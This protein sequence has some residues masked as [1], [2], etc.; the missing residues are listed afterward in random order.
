[1]LP[2]NNIVDF[3]KLIEKSYKHVIRLDVSKL[4]VK[5]LRITAGFETRS[6]LL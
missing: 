1:M 6:R 4:E 5:D 2:T 3:V